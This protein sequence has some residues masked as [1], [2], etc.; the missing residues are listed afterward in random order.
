M[1][2]QELPFLDVFRDATGGNVKTPRTEFLKEGEFP[3]VD[4]G[5]TLVA[6]FVNERSSVCSV[7]PPVIVFGDHTRVVKYVDFEFAMG[8]DGTKV[9]VPKV[10]S[11]TKYLYYALK[12]IEVP[13]AGYSRHYKFLKETRIP[14]PPLTEQKRISGI[15][16]AADTLRAKRREALAQIDTLLQS[17]FLDMFGDPVTN[18]MGWEERTLGEL[19]QNS[20]RNGL[21]PSTRGTID[22][23]VLT[24]SAITRGRFDFAARKIARF[25]RQPSP[26]QKLNTD[27]FLICRGNGNMKLVGTGAYPDR[28]SSLVCFPDTM[29]G[30][31]TSP[32]L[33]APAYLQNVWRTRRVR[34]QIE[35]GA[36]TTNGTHK[37][38]QRVLS[39]IVFPV[40]PLG[41]Q[42]QFAAIAES[43][44]QQEVRQRGH[45]AELD[46]LFASLQ[47]RAFDGE[48]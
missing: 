16:D 46:T 24:L 27:T 7:D 15:L 37:V 19:A 43:I 41:P 17:T 3:V 22:G 14:L 29:I 28:S 20:L 23:E 40:P 39:S 47:S 21:S 13:A 2:F 38:N 36:R 44:R 31:A 9:L 45:L 34:R 4:Q 11:D 42:L 48:L 32:S 30:V 35:R 18:P 25:D 1:S 33:M 5:R 26:S 6:G 8:A 12:A 10:E